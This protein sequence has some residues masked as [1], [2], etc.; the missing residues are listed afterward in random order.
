MTKAKLTKAEMSLELLRAPHLRVPHGFTTRTGGVSTGP[1]ASLNLGLSSGD[2]KTPVSENRRRVLAALGADEQRACA[3]SQ[4]H[5]TR[6]LEGAPSWFEEEA[7]AVVSNTP[8]LALVISTADCLPVLFYDPVTGAV[9]AAHCGW[10]GT[11]QGI[12]AATVRKL[13]ELYGSDPA[14]LHVAFGPAISRL[15]YQVGAEVVAEF[16]QTGFPETVY[17][18]DGS[19]RFLLDVAA[20]NRWA[21]LALGV[22]PVSL[23]ESG[24]C[25]YAD[26]E[27]FFSHRRDRGRTGRHWAVIAAG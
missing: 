27:R 11:V 3:F 23:W 7:D 18:P 17:E 8:G 24:R 13:T 15:N 9:G 2:G 26:P 1:Y 20:A 6:V 12:A 16:R 21:L 4:V 14:D 5:G 22:K 25:T 10:R 19:G